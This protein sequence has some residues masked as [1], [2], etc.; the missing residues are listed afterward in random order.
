MRSV[1][2]NVAIASATSRS[3]AGVGIVRARGQFATRAP[4]TASVNERE[5]VSDAC[6]PRTAER[7]AR[8][9]AR[10]CS[11]RMSAN[12][13]R[14]AD[15]GDEEAWERSL[16]EAPRRSFG[17]RAAVVTVATL[18]CGAFAAIASTHA[19]GGEVSLFASALGSSG[20]RAA[21]R[22][23]LVKHRATATNLQTSPTWDLQTR[24]RRTSSPT[25]NRAMTGTLG[26]AYKYI[27]DSFKSAKLGAVQAHALVEF[28]PGG[29]SDALA[30]DFERRRETPSRG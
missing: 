5:R 10:R 1:G 22:A 29:L 18:A 17:A 21:R 24:R 9:R 12:S 2:S 15:D 23:R 11:G 28:V 26:V 14:S 3:T 16:V 8:A 25:R 6:Q 19:T 7:S 13:P 30:Q 27:V 4:W 20:E